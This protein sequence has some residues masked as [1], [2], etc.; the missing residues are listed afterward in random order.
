LF[1]MKIDKKWSVPE[2]DKYD[3]IAEIKAKHPVSAEELERIM[4][5]KAMMFKGGS[6]IRKTFYVNNCNYFIYLAHRMLRKGGI[7]LPIWKIVVPDLDRTHQGSIYYIVQGERR[8]LMFRGTFGYWGTG[9]HEAA[10][11]E[12]FFELMF[13]HSDVSGNIVAPIEVRSGDYL[14]SFLL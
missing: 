11:I 8:N 13:G 1:K 4:K 5:G 10:K 3:N 14:L 7:K 2:Y 12:Q 9:P 6:R